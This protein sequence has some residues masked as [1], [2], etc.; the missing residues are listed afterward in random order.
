MDDRAEGLEAQLAAAMA[1]QADADAEV[2]ELLARLAIARK[3]ET[4]SAAPPD[5]SPAEMVTSHGVLGEASTSP[6][7]LVAVAAAVVR[8]GAGAAGG[9]EQVADSDADTC[10]RMVAL[11]MANSADLLMQRERTGLGSLLLQPLPLSSLDAVERGRPVLA[12]EFLPFIG[13][14]KHTLKLCPQSVLIASRSGT[15]WRWC[16]HLAAARRA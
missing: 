12:D 2:S 7:D 14:S 15:L 9:A 3:T 5:S 10:A 13:I 6:G 16:R 8:H 4:T 1:R 11:D